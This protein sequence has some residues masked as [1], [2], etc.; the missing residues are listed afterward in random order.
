MKLK[1]SVRGKN[2]TTAIF[3]SPED[4][5][6]TWITKVVSPQSPAWVRVVEP[7]GGRWS[8]I[9]I[10]PRSDHLHID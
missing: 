1:F 7:A 10:M 5:D 9:I 2:Y 6:V 3:I 4:Q 8:R